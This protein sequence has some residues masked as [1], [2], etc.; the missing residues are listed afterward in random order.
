MIVFADD[1]TPT[2]S[3]IDPTNLE[4]SIQE[5]GDKIVDWFDKNDMI[6][7]GDKTKLLIIGTQ[8]NRKSKLEMRNLKIKINI[9]NDE[10]NES[11]SEKLLGV[12]GIAIKTW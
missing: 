2:T 4:N 9:C 11:S 3:T 7:S 10:I 8:A 5:K 1:N 6:C 12:R